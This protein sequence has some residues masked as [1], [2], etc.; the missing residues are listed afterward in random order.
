MADH[1]TPESE[2]CYSGGGA[3]HNHAYLAPI[4]KRVLGQYRPA[5]VFDLGCGNGATSDWIRQQGHAVVGVDASP[6]GIVQARANY[7]EVEFIEGSAYDRLAER[8]GQFPMVV[9]LEVVEHLY[10][11]RS[12]AATVFDLLQPGGV[13]VISTPYHGYLKN[14]ALA[15]SGRMEQHFTALWDGGHIKFFS[16]RTLAQLLKDAGFEDV[17]FIRVGRIPVLAKSM[18]AIARKP[19]GTVS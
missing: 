13:S 11:P 12:F 19:T 6:S 17:R 18:V 9:S 10:A 7:P 2:Y 14:L 3:A 4:L 5:K 16:R 8:F 1:P 15:L